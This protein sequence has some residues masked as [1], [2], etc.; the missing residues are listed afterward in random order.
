VK[1]EGCYDD[2][3]NTEVDEVIFGFRFHILEDGEDGRTFFIDVPL[4]K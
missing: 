3:G 2:S 4:Q 1:A